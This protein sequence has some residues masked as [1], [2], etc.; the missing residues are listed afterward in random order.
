MRR[1]ALGLLATGALLA[2]CVSS[3]AGHERATATGQTFLLVRHAE[4]STDDPRDPSLTPA[5][6]ARAQRLAAELHNAPLVAVYS[7]D[8][9]RTRAT[10]TPAAQ[11]HGLAVVP[12]DARMAD[13]FASELRARHRGGLVLV[14]GHSNTVPTLA[15]A[16]CGCAVAP[17]AE[18]DYGLRYR[19][20][21]TGV[22]SPARLEAEAW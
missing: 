12:Y 6:E 14:V 5:G 8:T 22:A 21:E 17:M 1:S 7:T 19:L 20:H 15:A 18:Q 3:P 9:R 4:K 10:A 16:L 11:M 13:A 2:G